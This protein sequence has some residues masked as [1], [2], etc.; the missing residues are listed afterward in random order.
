[1]RYMADSVIDARDALS[2]DVVDGIDQWRVAVHKRG[3]VVTRMPAA[4]DLDNA[5]KLA[6]RRGGA[7][8]SEPTRAP[9]YTLAPANVLKLDGKGAAVLRKDIAAGQK[10]ADIEKALRTVKDAALE[11]P[12]NALGGLFGIPPGIVG[13]I[14]LLIGGVVGWRMLDS[15]AP[16]RN[17]PRGV[18]RRK[19][20]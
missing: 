6:E 14:V 11:A 19:A 16:R 15:F 9:S 18:R 5:H 1:M 17:P 8:S 10:I 12:R 7:G 20:R 4:I 2:G 3:H 13:P